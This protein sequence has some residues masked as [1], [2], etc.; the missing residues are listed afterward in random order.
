MQLVEPYCLISD[1]L[2]LFYMQAA[3]KKLQATC[4]V[5]LAII[6]KLGCQCVTPKVGTKSLGDD[7]DSTLIQAFEVQ[8]WITSQ[9]GGWRFTHELSFFDCFDQELVPQLFR[10]W[11]MGHEGKQRNR[12]YQQV[13]VQTPCDLQSPSRSAGETLFQSNLPP[14]PEWKFT[15]T[16]IPNKDRSL[17]RRFGFIDCGHCS[18]VSINV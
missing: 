18:C 13:C 14:S 8:K 3:K 11:V 7:K 2:Q 12:A 6:S 16:R 4:H 10:L 9:Y 15:W 1:P 17:S 5:R